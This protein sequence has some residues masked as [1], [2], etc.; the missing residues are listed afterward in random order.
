MLKTLRRII[1]EVASAQDFKEALN[2]MVKRVAKA[3]DTEACSIF[4]LD[5][6]RSEY[7]L[8][9]TQGLNLQAVG[10]V[11]VPI[12]QGL[13]GFVGEREEPVNIDDA[14]KHPRF[15]SV[16]E[17][18][19]DQYKAFLGTPI[20]YHRQVLGVLIV[21][22]EQPRRYDESEEAFLATLA[23]QLA[24]IIA[25]AEAIG[26]VASL[27][28]THQKQ[29]TTTYSGIPSSPGV[30]V[31]FG[32]VVYSLSDLDAVPDREPDDIDTEI[33]LLEAALAAGREDFRILGERLYSNLPLE[34]RAL[35]DVYQRM[36]DE[37]DLGAEIIH[38]IRNGNWA[39]GA[40][41]KVIQA[42]VHHL[43]NLENEYLRE[44]AVDIKD[45]G[46]RVLGYL[47]RN[48]RA[49]PQ[50][51]DRTI[52]IGEQLSA[53]DLA[54]VPEGCLAGVI[55]A[56]GSS[57]SHVAILARAMKLPTVM[58]VSDIPIYE[59][60]DREIIVDGYYGQIY[61]DPSSA[62]REEFQHL[63]QE[64]RELDASLEVLRDKPAQTKDRHR[65]SLMVNTGLGTD[66]SLS[67]AAGAEGV[68]LYRTETPFL[69]RDRF[70][71]GEEQRV[72]YR[73]LLASFS[74][75]PVTMRT[76][77]IG[78]DKSLP[79][80]PVKEDNPFL[81]WRGIRITLDHPE[82]FLVQVRAM[83]RASESYNNL[84]IM[85]PM[86]TDVSEVDEAV[87]LLKK[88]F[89]DVRDEGTQIEMP[90]V[91][92]MIEVPSA[93]YQARSLAKRVDF[94]SVGSNDL[95]QYLLAVDRNN[96]RVAN[97]YDSLHP[98]VIRALLQV[99]DAGHQEGKHV[100]ICGEMAGDPAAVLLL[101]AMGFDSLSMSASS[102]ARMKW[103]IRQFSMKKAS[104]LL[105]E[106]LGMESPVMIR[107][108]MELALE[109]VGLGGLIRAGKR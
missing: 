102:I 65:I 97:L 18:G 30:G 51:S 9:A 66:V 19:E 80:F 50:Y 48:D 62:L 56:K 40:L 34:E 64:E 13:V 107:C 71:S 85:L 20:I 81:G 11:R 26:V 88:A 2:I 78:G 89:T 42:H 24:A 73:Q 98:A 84:R 33:R 23:T 25:H 37:S 55:S 3:L 27:L 91:G 49:L 39:Q 44:R 32:V 7:V 59:S 29:G 95:T 17:V 57:S 6:R 93:V 16:P 68:G 94:L 1:Q 90:E 70:P 31:G 76:L 99:V 69:M 61:I 58:G 100:S 47:Q 60:Q 52:L 15:L 43:E 8:M 46:H 12:N 35:F 108:H 53:A 4:L 10:S 36:L 28:D 86:V 92:V 22:Q 41:R 79:Y 87:R 83:M 75:R 45:L 101:V 38:V 104:K 54:E 5:R 21:Q 67:L 103:V 106:V 109:K 74:P 14:H 63:A 105:Q 77:D 96:S 82:I 72:I